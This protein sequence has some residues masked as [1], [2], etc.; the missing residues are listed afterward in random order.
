MTGDAQS[1]AALD[2]IKT[3]LDANNTFIQT[4]AAEINAAL[5]QCARD[6]AKQVTALKSAHVR[7]DSEVATK[8]ADLKARGLAVGNMAELK[9][10]LDRKS[11]L[12]REIATVELKSNDLRMTRE[13]RAKL[14]RELAETRQ[15]MTDRRK[16]QLKGINDN[17][18]LTI[19]DY[20]IFVKYDDEGITDEFEAYMQSEMTGTYL[21]DNVIE[22]VCNSIAPAQ[23]SEMILK[24][25]V[26]KIAVTAKIST[27]QAEKIVGKM[28]TFR[29]LYELEVLAKPPK[30][31]IVVLTKSIP[32]KEIPVFQLSDGQRHTILLTIAMLADSNVPLVIDQPED[33]L[34][35][36]FIFSSI[37][38][39][40]R[41]IKERRQV[42]VVTH[43]AN[44]AVLG[45]SELILP[46]YRENDYGKAKTRG[47]IDSEA[48]RDCVQN[49][50]EGG[51]AAFLRRKEIYGH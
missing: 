44:I 27:D 25:D 31:V 8:L 5:K 13:E 30:P 24:Q 51:A 1:Q 15:M 21:Y 18:A 42:I 22:Q 50:L 41:T 16:A 40:L 26:N 19:Q 49:I 17:L 39:T 38:T 29:D 12:G 28:R 2:E 48:T 43:N 23:L 20:K 3:L 14:L 4:R 37:V 47:S 35:N 46:M 34:D 9:Q 6:L 45:D 11:T 10:L 32:Q 36:G 33:D 7:L